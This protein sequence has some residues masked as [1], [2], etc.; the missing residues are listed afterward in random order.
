MSTKRK[1]EKESKLTVWN[2]DGLQIA[3]LPPA[4]VRST[5]AT[6]H[7][8]VGPVAGYWFSPMIFTFNNID[9]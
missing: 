5:I 9:E 7:I 4:A 3:T 2:R 8:T 1:R 6:M